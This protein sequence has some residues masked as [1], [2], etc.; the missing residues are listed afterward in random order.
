MSRGYRVTWV[1]TTRTV[2]ASDRLELKLSLL[3]ILPEDEMKELLRAELARDGWQTTPNGRTSTEM[4]GTHVELA[5]DGKS[6]TV[7]AK[8]TRT[9]DGG[10]VTAQAA[11][12][13]AEQATPSAQNKLQKEITGR[14]A[15]LEPDLRARV[16]QAVQRV[17]VEA[18]KRKAAT[19]GQVE[20]LRETT[21]EDGTQEVT[22]KVRV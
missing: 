18:L 19:L 15:R 9:V 1:R 12:A 20:S 11:A 21:L 17:Y 4:D 14:L 13:A 7:E 10:G 16:E 2:T 8:G 3:E 22:I 5:P 6:V